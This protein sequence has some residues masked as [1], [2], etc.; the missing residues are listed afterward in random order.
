MIWSI[1]RDDRTRI[2]LATKI[3]YESHAMTLSNIHFFQELS[4][5]EIIVLRHGEIVLSSSLGYLKFD[6]P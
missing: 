5:T 6:P 1:P 4:P 3:S 2:I